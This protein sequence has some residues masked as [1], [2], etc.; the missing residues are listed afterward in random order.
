MNHSNTRTSAKFQFVQLLFLIGFQ[1]LLFYC[2]PSKEDLAIASGKE[3]YQTYCALC[4]GQEGDG[5]GKLA[6]GK[7]PAPANLTLSAIPDIAKREIIIKGGEAVGRS[8]FMPP[9]GQE[10]TEK[11]VDDLIAYINSISRIKKH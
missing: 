2:G 4:H 6:I 10:F 1:S 3:T 11:Q 9:W 8:P 7:M 5:K